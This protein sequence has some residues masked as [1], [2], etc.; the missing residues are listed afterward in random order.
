MATAA[1]PT[2]ARTTSRRQT[3]Y[4]A[5][6]A[7][8]HQR[9]PSE[10]LRSPASAGEGNRT[11]YAS[12]AHQQSLAAVARR[13]YE[14]TN[15]AR[16][17]P[18][19]RSSSRD[20]A[21]APTSPGQPGQRDDGGRSH[22]RADSRSGAP[23]YSSDMPRT[24]ASA[25]Y[26]NYQPSSARSKGDASGAEQAMPIRKRTTITAQTGT[27]SLGKTVGAGSMGK[28]KIAKN[29]ETGE[30][31][32][33]L[34]HLYYSGLSGYLTVRYQ[35]CSTSIDRRACYRERAPARGPLERN[36]HSSR[37]CDRDATQPPIYLW[38]EG[39]CEDKLPLVY[40]L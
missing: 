16:T 12:P 27:W 4:G 22:H 17:Q 38:H 40:A 29:G 32:G 5:A 30:T 14:T 10:S 37:G 15:V 1:G 11:E 6:A 20:P 3:A 33:N 7:E 13:D 9:T 23:R 24:P 31:V 21:Y 25:G 39:R 18:G 8:K 35:D 36:T 34:L 19:R 28:V 2:M 26:N